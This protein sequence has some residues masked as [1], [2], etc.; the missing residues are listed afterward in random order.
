MSDTELPK[1]K[2]I[3]N[4][5]HLNKDILSEDLQEE[6]SEMICNSTK[7]NNFEAMSLTNSGRNMCR[8]EWGTVNHKN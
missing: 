1:I 8:G 5:F 6:F 2:M 3:R 7:K 4:P